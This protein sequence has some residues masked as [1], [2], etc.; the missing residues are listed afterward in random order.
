MKSNSDLPHK[1]VREKI[2][3]IFLRIITF[4]VILYLALIIFSIRHQRILPFN[5]FVAFMLAA[6]VMLLSSVMIKGKRIKKYLQLIFVR[7]EAQFVSESVEK[8]DKKVK[9]FVFSIGYLIINLL[10]ILI[11]GIALQLLFRK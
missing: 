5:N 6:I 2:I 9:L 7:S 10:I 8:A 11:I 1:T 4:I 3:T